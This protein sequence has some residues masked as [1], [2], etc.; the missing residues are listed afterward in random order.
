MSSIIIKKMKK[1][2]NRNGVDKGEFH[3]QEI[4]KMDYT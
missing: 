1:M 2:K 3:F 4:K